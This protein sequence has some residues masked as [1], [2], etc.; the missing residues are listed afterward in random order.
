MNTLNR[1]E[2]LLYP[3]V[4]GIN[5]Q[6]IMRQVYVWMGLGTLLTAVVAY[7]TASTALINLAANPVVLIVALLAELGMVLGLSFGLNRLAVGTATALFF[8]A[9]R[10]HAFWRS[11]AGRGCGP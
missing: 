7:F 4:G 1:N 3:A 9:S 11:A 5:L 2:N 6:P 8:A 10:G